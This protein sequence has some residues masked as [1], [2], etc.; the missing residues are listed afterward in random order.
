M[1]TVGSRI[2]FPNNDFVSTGT[3]T[4][5]NEDRNE[6]KINWDDGFVDDEDTWYLS[7]EINLASEQ[8]MSNFKATESGF[9]MKFANG[10]TISVFWS[11][12]NNPRAEIAAW[13]KKGE[14]Y[15]FD[16]DFVCTYLSTDQVAHYIHLISKFES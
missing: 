2:E 6:Y 5:V 3:I 7:R 15:S 12:Y 9:N 10:W 13:N 4:E 1:F 16:G 11:T 14:W 8:M